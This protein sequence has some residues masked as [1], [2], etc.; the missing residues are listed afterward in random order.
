MLRFFVAWMEVIP[1]AWWAQFVIHLDIVSSM[2]L[3]SLLS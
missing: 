3:N 1:P 2:D